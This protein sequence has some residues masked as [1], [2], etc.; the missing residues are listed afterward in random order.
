MNAYAERPS[1]AVP[2]EAVQW[3]EVC[4]RLQDAAQ[5]SKPGVRVA[6]GY[7][8]ETLLAVVERLRQFDRLRAALERD[9]LEQ[10]L[11]GF[12]LRKYTQRQ[13]ARQKAMGLQYMDAETHDLAQELSCFLA[14][15][16]SH[17]DASTKESA[18]E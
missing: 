6:W 15:Y 11:L 13:D 2:Q 16:V 1:C 9:S 3:Q 12:L 18:G 4:A 7:T 14:A 8:P 10:A 17:N 5:R